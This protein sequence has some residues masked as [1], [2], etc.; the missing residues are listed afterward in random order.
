MRFRQQFI[1]SFI[2]VEALFIFSIVF[3]NL[4]AI[5][6]T[7]ENLVTQQVENYKLLLQEVLKTP[8]MMNDLATIDDAI[9][10]F[11][12]LEHIVLV[13]VHDEQGKQISFVESQNPE[14]LGLLRQNNNLLN[15][16]KD[17]SS[18]LHDSAE[19]D[20]KK[21]LRI[22]FNIDFNHQTL[23]YIY[24][25]F[26]KTDLE[27]T[28]TTNRNF[29]LLMAIASI[30]IGL[31][32]AF[33]I[34]GKIS[35]SLH[36]LIELA[37]QVAK[38]RQVKINEAEWKQNELG[39][40]SSAMNAM[41][42]KIKERTD[43]LVK[44]EQQAKQASK[45]KSDFLAVMSHEIRTPLNGMI[46]S[47]NLMDRQTLSQENINYLETIHSSSELLLTV[48][49]DVLDFSK[50]EAGKLE[51]SLHHL[52]ITTMIKSIEN[53]Y[54]NIAE[55]QGLKFISDTSGLKH[56]TYVGDEIRIKQIINNF[57]SNALKFTDSGEIR[58][59]ARNNETGAVVIQIS[60]TG[61]GI[62]KTQQKNLFG[63]FSQVH[64]GFS[65][66]Y[67]GTGLGLAINKRLLDLMHA[68][69]KV[70]STI[71]E[72]STFSITLP[73]EAIEQQEAQQNQ[74][75]L[76]EDIPDFSSLNIL[77][78][79]DNQV[80]QM[81]ASKML[82]KTKC[83]ITIASNG[84]EA[85]EQTQKSEFDMIL[86]DCQMPEMD[87]LEATQ[88]LRKHGIKTPIIALTANTQASDKEICT[89]AGM[90]DFLS[91]PFNPLELY[92]KMLHLL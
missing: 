52:D 47:L 68:E 49:N 65:R 36:R 32:I 22:K 12:T 15:S 35:A 76:S 53:T 57:V 84:L 45:A 2:L 1:L 86:M 73:L 6:E 64:K 69:V 27:N 7:S 3:F 33:M 71:D 58:I 34:S 42:Q 19:I 92:S 78:V 11:A 63:E 21:L 62:D 13:S 60:D 39:E 88:I 20:Q 54:R 14:Y 44:A 80:N 75:E 8:L 5:K 90:D 9:G 17:F 41:Q 50:I 46:G 67:G 72:G 85:I 28:I 38:G 24:F 48:I 23:G 91:K 87:G 30:I 82:E 25:V 83:R 66:K 56:H 55:A 43:H 51:L 4:T 31:L 61:I 29:S 59:E 18:N 10:Y 40:L 79:E 37:N 81:V 74:L 77:L 26:D 89:N 16:F 70:E